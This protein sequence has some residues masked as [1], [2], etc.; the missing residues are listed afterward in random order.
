VIGVIIGFLAGVW[1][2]GALAYFAFRA[3]GGKGFSSAQTAPVP[4]PPA[5]AA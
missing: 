4:P 2:A 3:A 5:P 1:G